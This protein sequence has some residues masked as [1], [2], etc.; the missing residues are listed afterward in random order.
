MALSSACRVRP[1]CGECRESEDA[2]QAG[3]PGQAGMSGGPQVQKVLCVQGLGESS[4]VGRQG[5]WGPASAL[6]VARKASGLSDEVTMGDREQ[7]MR[8]P[9][10]PSLLEGGSA[11]V[12]LQ[13]RKSTPAGKLPRAPLGGGY[14]T[15]VSRCQSESSS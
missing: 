15:R 5:T 1:D 8:G 2:G 6:A 13:L 3:P 9:A 12:P 11:A 14:L 10:L 7:R 4:Q